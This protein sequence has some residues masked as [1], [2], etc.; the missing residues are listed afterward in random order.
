M[1]I[2]QKVRARL[3]LDDLRAQLARVEGSLRKHDD[4]LKTQ[5][6]LIDK[7]QAVIANQRQRLTKQQERI[8]ELAER[9][10]SAEVRASRVSTVYAVLEQQIASM[11]TRLDELSTQVRDDTLPATQGEREEGRKL[12]DEIREEHSRIRARF[13]VMVRYEER[14]RRLEIALKPV[15]GA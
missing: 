15:P 8:A 14:I 7:Q 10:E 12:L 9:A 11:E 3:G 13:G 4:R 5:R 1:T 6:A 2:K